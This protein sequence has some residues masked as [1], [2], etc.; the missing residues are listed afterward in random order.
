MELV[1]TL[2]EL[3]TNM[4]TLDR[5]LN[6]KR[7]PT[8]T[9]A[10]NLIKHGTCF[11]A[12]E[13]SN[14][15]RFYPSRFLGYAANTMSSHLNNDQKDGRETNP[16]ISDLLGHKPSENAHLEHA[17][18]T[19]CETLGFTAQATGAFGVVRKYWTLP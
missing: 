5:Y 3:H 1:Q 6:Q 11:V 13:M 16:V 2:Q 4:E 7:E 10:L 9:F 18:Q 8:Y 14:G 15:F 17:Y 12:V 19:Y